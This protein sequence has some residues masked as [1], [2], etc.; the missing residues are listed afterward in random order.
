[1]GG[2]GPLSA[3]H[4]YSDNQRDGRNLKTL[5]VYYIIIFE[6]IRIRVTTASRYSNCFKCFRN[7]KK[8][9]GGH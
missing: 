9:G 8:E 2:S 6:L 4:T 3:V 1:M 7:I 5:Q